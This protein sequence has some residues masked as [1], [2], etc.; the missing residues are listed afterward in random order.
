MPPAFFNTLLGTASAEF[1]YPI[2]ARI[3][4]SR[5][6]VSANC[7]VEGITRPFGSSIDHLTVAELVGHA[8]G[9]M[10]AEVYSHLGGAEGHLREALARGSV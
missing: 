7:S 9:A 4:Q 3:S 8:D 1:L 6:F 10:F 2:S 5:S